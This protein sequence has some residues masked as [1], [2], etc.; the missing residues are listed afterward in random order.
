MDDKTLK[1]LLEM[2][3]KRMLGYD[4]DYEFIKKLKKD[5]KF[6]LKHPNTDIEKYYYNLVLEQL[7]VNEARLKT[8]SLNVN[9]KIIFFENGIVDIDNRKN[10]MECCIELNVKVGR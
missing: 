10:K 1:K 2:K 4:I 7:K 3:K 8:D 5:F 6:I 9:S